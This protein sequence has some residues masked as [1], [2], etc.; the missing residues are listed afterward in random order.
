[1]KSTFHEVGLG[2]AVVQ[3]VTESGTEQL[4]VTLRAENQPSIE[5]QIKENTENRSTSKGSISINQQGLQKLF[6]WLQEEGAV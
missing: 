6:K 1:M 2:Q 4:I 5:I 3:N